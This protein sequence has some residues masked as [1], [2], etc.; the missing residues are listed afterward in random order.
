MTFEEVNSMIEDGEREL[1]EFLLDSQL[2]QGWLQKLDKA[3][4]TNFDLLVYTLMYKYK[5]C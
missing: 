5:T 3:S 4:D 1:A 2:F